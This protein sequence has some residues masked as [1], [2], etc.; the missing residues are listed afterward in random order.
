MWGIKLPTHPSICGAHHK[1]TK[2]YAESVHDAA[3]LCQLMTS[4][5]TTGIQMGEMSKLG[6]LI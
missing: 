6:W 5:L 4:L 3:L 2:S 1:Q